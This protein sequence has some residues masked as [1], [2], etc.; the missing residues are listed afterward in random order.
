MTMGGATR[1]IRQPRTDLILGF[2]TAEY[3]SRTRTDGY[4]APQE[5]WLGSSGRSGVLA[6]QVG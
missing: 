4:A 1:M 2:L 3:Q 6:E 5:M